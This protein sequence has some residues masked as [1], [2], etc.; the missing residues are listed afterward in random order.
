MSDSKLWLI[1]GILGQSVFFA[2]F[3]AQWIASERKRDSV[4][5]IAFWWLSLA[6]GMTTLFYAIHREEPVW[7]VGQAMGIFIYTR[8]LMLVAKGKRRAAHRAPQ[9]PGSTIP[10]SHSHRVDMGEAQSII[11][12]AAHRHG[13]NGVADAHGRSERGT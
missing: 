6:G 8:N 2:R 9:S 7:A 10:A 5:P 11:R 13:E 3:L 12:S 1:I 4:V